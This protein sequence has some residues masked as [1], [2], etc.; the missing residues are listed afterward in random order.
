MSLS[1]QCTYA[2]SVQIPADAVS[3]PHPT[4]HTLNLTEKKK[5]KLNLAVL[6]EEPEP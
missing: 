5:K 3:E 4:L 2:D 6:E 1:S